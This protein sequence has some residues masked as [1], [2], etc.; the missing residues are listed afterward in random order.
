MKPKCLVCKSSRITIVEYWG[1]RTIEWFPGSSVGDGMMTHE[2]NPYKVEW[3]CD[4]C[5]KRTR[6]RG[7]QVNPDWFM[8]LTE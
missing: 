3:V 2:D 4:N 1:G 8:E 7:V 5:G 6:K